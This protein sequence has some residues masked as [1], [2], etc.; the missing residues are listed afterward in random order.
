L[1]RK[2]PATAFDL[3]GFDKSGHGEYNPLYESNDASLVVA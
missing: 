3:A 2:C 1:I